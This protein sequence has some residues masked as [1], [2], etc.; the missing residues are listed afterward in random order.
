MQ[1]CVC[2]K[3]HMRV[4]CFTLFMWFAWAALL[5]GIVKIATGKV[6]NTWSFAT[7]RC[8]NARTQM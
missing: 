4:D 2:L 6:Q 3:E 8:L 7:G 5:A 1:M